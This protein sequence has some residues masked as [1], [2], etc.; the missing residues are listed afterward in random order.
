MKTDLKAFVF[1]FHV[2]FLGFRT[3]GQKIPKKE[4]NSGLN[5]GY[6]M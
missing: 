1:H 2:S 5:E 4:K 6:H 3:E